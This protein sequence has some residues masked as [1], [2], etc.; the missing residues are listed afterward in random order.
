[1]KN[2]LLIKIFVILALLSVIFLVVFNAKVSSKSLTYD[3][4]VEYIQEG[5]VSKITFLGDNTIEIILSNGVSKEST[6]PSREEFSAFISEEIQNGNNIEILVKKDFSAIITTLPVIILTI[7]IIIYIYMIG[8]NFTKSYLPVTSNVNFD[9]VAGID[10]EKAQLQE[11]VSFL[12]NPSKYHLMG[13][14]IP[15]GILLN[16]EP[17]TGKTLLA[18]AIAGEAKVPFFEANGSSFEEKF[19]G[20][21]ASRIRNLFKAAKKI[22][23]CIIFIDEFDAVAKSRYSERNYSEQTLN[24]LL[25]EMDGFESRDNVIVIAATN[26]FEVLDSAIVRPGR[27]DRHVFVP[28]PDV[29]AREEILRIHAKD[30]ILD[31]EINLEEIAKKT[32]GFSGADLANVLNEA[33]IQAVNES[34]EA[35][36]KQHIDEAIVR[37]LVGLEKKNSAITDEEKN[38]TAIHESGHAIVSALL[39]PQVKNFGI[40][41]IPRGKGAGGYNFFN[42]SDKK[43]LTKEDL[44]AK[45]KVL[46]AGRLAEEVILGQVSSGASNDFEV[47]T[48]IAQKMMN[49]FAMDKYLLVNVNGEEKYNEFLNQ[50]RL[51]DVEEF[52]KKIYSDTYNLVKSYKVQIQKMAELL[53]EKEYL[54]QQEIENFVNQNLNF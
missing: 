6:V 47:A 14:K 43:Y 11:I 53:K 48:K 2:R 37:V 52:C 9:M 25:S 42:E 54:S 36:K 22:A 39:R 17:G 1:M 34:C 4:V 16:G 40:S 51:E 23:P 32:V 3:E 31:P 19:V 26:H 49:E 21:G 38:I 45:I 13:A 44:E 46:Y 18:K 20:V 33:A 7:I 24:Q 30:K 27:F 50:K 28:M 15:K 29:T 10:E 5:Y 8:K 41:I 12:R 35:I